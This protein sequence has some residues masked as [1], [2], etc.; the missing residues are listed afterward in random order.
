MDASHA[1]GAAGT[2]RSVVAALALASWSVVALASSDA[3]RMGEPLRLGRAARVVV[4]APHPDDE[5]IA[6]GGL[7]RRL[8]GAG[9]TVQVVFVTSGD[10]YPDAVRASLH[11]RPPDAADYLAYGSLRRRE[12][13]DATRRLGLSRAAVHFLAFPD[14]GLDALWQSHWGRD[15]PYT[16]PYTGS[17]SP[18]YPGVVD[19]H[20]EYDGQDLT[21]ALSEVLAAAHPTLVVMPHPD[22][23]HLDHA[24]TARFVVEAIER[25][26]ARHVLPRDLELITYLVHDPLWPPTAA[27]TAT[28]PPPRRIHDT[29]WL[30]FPLSAEEQAA[31]AAALRAYASQLAFMPDLLA[32]FLRPNELFGRVDPGVI[33]RIASRH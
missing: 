9:A 12:A 7:I 15:R 24:A 11:G 14:G 3:T 29:E 22:D 10:G 18:P 2:V 33:A 25:L 21:A 5:T 26:H 4:V 20:A 16:S 17:D 23:V 1:G 32:R 19:P 6:A 13:L 27:E 28:L 8:V 30:Q 31:K